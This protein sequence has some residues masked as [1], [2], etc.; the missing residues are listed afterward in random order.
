MLQYQCV[1][2]QTCSSSVQ[3]ALCYTIGVWQ[4][5]AAVSV[6]SLPHAAV[7]MSEVHNATIILPGL[8][9]QCCSIN[10]R[11]MLQLHQSVLTV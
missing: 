1:A 5:D 10:A 3:L 7:S 4:P 11:L 8:P 2:Y 9:T 6:Y